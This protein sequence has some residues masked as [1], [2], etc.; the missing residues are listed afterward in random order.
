MNTQDANLYHALE[1]PP[2]ADELYASFLDL[3]C[4][5]EPENLTC[6]GELDPLLVELRRRRLL[7]K[8]QALERKAGR[9]VTKD[10]VWQRH[11][12]WMDSLGNRSS[13]F[14]E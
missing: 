8:W 5:W 4:Q 9:R 3:A 12:C 7:R 1:D 10:E 6:D 13:G 11:F 14:F 2:L